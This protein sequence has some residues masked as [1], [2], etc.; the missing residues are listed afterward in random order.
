MKE[1]DKYYFKFVPKAK[2]N[3]L[4]L[5][6]LWEKA[7]FDMSR[8]VFDTVHY[9]SVTGLAADLKISVSTLRRYLNSESYND[10][11]TLD[12]ENKTIILKNNVKEIKP[13]VQL[14]KQQVAVLKQ[15]KDNLLCKYVI[16]LAYYCGI[17]KKAG[18]PQDFTTKQF[19]AACGYSNTSNSYLGK[20]SGFNSLLVR[21]KIIGITYKRDSLGYCRNIYSLL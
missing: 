1:R 5:F 17:A 9:Q 14:T 21:E 11:F 16:Y 18:K 8:R 10:F 3:Y 15:Q 2:V 13:F 7:E 6:S 12:K 20:I 4:F 19:L